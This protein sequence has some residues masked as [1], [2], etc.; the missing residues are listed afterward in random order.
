MLVYC[1]TLKIKNNID[2]NIIYNNFGTNIPNYHK[3]DNY[4]YLFCVNKNINI[5]NICNNYNCE[6]INLFTM[7]INENEY[8]NLYKIQFNYMIN[9]D[10]YELVQVKTK[11]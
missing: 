1:F 3:I 9:E 2:I 6:I 11:I 10:P 8:N 5:K 4:Q 7:D